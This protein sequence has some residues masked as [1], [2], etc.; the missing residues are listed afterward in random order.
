MI[1]LFVSFR[2]YSETNSFDEI[3]YNCS[4]DQNIGF[5]PVKDYKVVKMDLKKFEIKVNFNKKLIKSED[6]YFLGYKNSDDYKCFKS[7]HELYCINKVG[8]SFSIN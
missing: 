5:D 8:Y 7:Y 3:I 6:N 4:E 1:C 2:V